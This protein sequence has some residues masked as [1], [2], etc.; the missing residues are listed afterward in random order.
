MLGRIAAVAAGLGA[1]VVARG[2]IAEGAA[3][4]G[5][6]AVAAELGA[7]EAASGPTAANPGPTGARASPIP[8]LFDL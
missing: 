2:Q 1:M 5:V 3:E 6:T 4:L 8:D 7:M